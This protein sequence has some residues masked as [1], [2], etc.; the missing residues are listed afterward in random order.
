[1]TS[2]NV[3]MKQIPVSPNDDYMAGSDGRI[4]SRT[5]YAGFGKKE[6]VDWY[7]LVGSVDKRKGYVRIS[8]CHRNKRVT[9]LVH[10]LVCMAFHG[11]PAGN[12]QVRHLD[13]NPKN[14]KPTNLA[15][16]TYEENWADRRAHGR[17]RDRGEHC[18]A[19]FTNEERAHIAWAVEHG[20]CSRRGAA[21][22]LGVANSTIIELCARER[23]TP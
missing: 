22:V 23:V 1:M 21:K 5:K 10:R 17:A 19:R 16:G 14:N 15:W 6:L 20:L 9:A 18:A 4:Y 13:G 11:M 7:P 3:E 12:L 2:A 8:L